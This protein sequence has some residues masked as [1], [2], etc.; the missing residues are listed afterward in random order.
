[1]NKKGA[2]VFILLILAIVVISMVWFGGLW[3]KIS[4][5]VVSSGISCDEGVMA[6]YNF[7]D[8]V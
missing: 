4:G 8:N 7:Q 3:S 2:L 6:Y 5:N 1:M